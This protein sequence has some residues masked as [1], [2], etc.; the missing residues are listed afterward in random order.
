LVLV[1]GASVSGWVSLSVRGSVIRAAM[2]AGVM[3]AQMVTWCRS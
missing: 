2:V 3:V 1:A